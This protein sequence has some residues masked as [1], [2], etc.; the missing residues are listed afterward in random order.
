MDILKERWIAVDG[1][2]YTERAVPVKSEFT[3][4]LMAEPQHTAVAFNVGTK[5]ASH[6]VNQ[7]NYY[8]PFATELK[9][10]DAYT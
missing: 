3:G 6:I 10:S 7:H 2:I 1:S 5:V 4:K 9:A 8:L